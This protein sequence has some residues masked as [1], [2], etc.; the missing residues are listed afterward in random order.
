MSK[1]K[2]LFK[3]IWCGFWTELRFK[4]KIISKISLHS[5]V[6][7]TTVSSNFKLP[8]IC[9]LF[10][11]LSNKNLSICKEV[12]KYVSPCYITAFVFISHQVPKAERKKRRKKETDLVSHNLLCYKKVIF[13]PAVW[14]I[15]YSIYVDIFKE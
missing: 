13:R 6:F 11:Y 2:S 1:V 3:L 14:S 10:C 15:S 12:R 7:M 9:L 5:V 8:P 4:K